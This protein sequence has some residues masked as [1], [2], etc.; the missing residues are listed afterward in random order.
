[1]SGNEALAASV[2][3]EVD[4]VH[5][6]VVVPVAQFQPG[7]L[8]VGPTSPGGN[9]SVTLNGPTAVSGPSLETVTVQE[10]SSPATASP[11]CVF[12]TSTSAASMCATASS[13]PELYGADGGPVLPS[14]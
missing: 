3:A 13:G 9:V 4:R 2:S 5:S 1:M 6:I 12:S 7:P 11:V 10:K 14:A 8:A